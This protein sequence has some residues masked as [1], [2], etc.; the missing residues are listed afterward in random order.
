M[1]I[2]NCSFVATDSLLKRCNEGLLI[3]VDT[4]VLYDGC[5]WQPFN[6][7]LRERH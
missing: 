5:K 4:V 7:H 3:A 2:M 6:L 1:Y